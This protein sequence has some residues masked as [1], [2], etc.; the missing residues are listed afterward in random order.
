VGLRLGVVSRQQGRESLVP[1]SMLKIHATM[2]AGGFLRVHAHV[3]VL[4]GVLHSSA[5]PR[6]DKCLG[7]LH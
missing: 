3:L 2:G 7:G 6:T 5:A 1:G 4:A